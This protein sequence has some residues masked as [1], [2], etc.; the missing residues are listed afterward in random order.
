VSSIEPE[1]LDTRRT[2]TVSVIALIRAT[3]A[4]PAAAGG[5]HTQFE[6]AFL[7]ACGLDANAE[8]NSA[9]T[10]F[11]HTLRFMYS[12]CNRIFLCD[13]GYQLLSQ[14]AAHWG[15]TMRSLYPNV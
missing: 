12:V 13:M 5:E 2:E 6:P 7:S 9:R 3:D 1:F 8:A 15:E 10:A 4:A 14:H 11:V